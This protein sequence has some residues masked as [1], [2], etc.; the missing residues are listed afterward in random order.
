MTFIQCRE[1]VWLYLNQKHFGPI[2]AI[3]NHCSS[4]EDGSI[5][6]PTLKIALQRLTTTSYAIF[7]GIP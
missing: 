4:Y 6:C 3:L 1:A 2:R 5:L 7:R